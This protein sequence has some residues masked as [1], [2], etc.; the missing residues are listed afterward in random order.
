MELRASSDAEQSQRRLQQ[1][2]R[3]INSI[4][5]IM[6]YPVVLIVTKSCGYIA[7]LIISMLAKRSL[8]EIL[9][10]RTISTL[11]NLQA[12]AR[13]LTEILNLSVL[14]LNPALHSALKRSAWRQHLW[15]RN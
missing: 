7:L 13:T 8:D 4:L 10:Q 5:R 2:R 11:H 14:L 6:L 3:L 1:R 12:H 15:H 9:S